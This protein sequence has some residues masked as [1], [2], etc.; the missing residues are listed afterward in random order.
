MP[1]H[2]HGPTTV[3]TE[4]VP[5]FGSSLSPESLCGKDLFPRRVL[6]GGGGA[7]RRED[8]VEAVRSLGHTLQGNSPTVPCPRSSLLYGILATRWSSF[9]PSR[10]S[11]TM[12]ASPPS[13]SY[14]ANQQGVKTLKPWAKPFSLYKPTVSGIFIVI[15]SRLTQRD[16]Q[17]RGDTPLAGH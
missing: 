11:A 15:E 16:S 7:F 1:S 9:P 10:V 5:Q 2:L 3:G 4:R 14:G 17:L 6:V 8:L 13:Q 12:C